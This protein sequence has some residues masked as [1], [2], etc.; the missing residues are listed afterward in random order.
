M[1][2]S[3]HTLFLWPATGWWSKKLYLWTKLWL[4]I[5]IYYQSTSANFPLWSSPSHTPECGFTVHTAV[6]CVAPQSNT[7]VPSENRKQKQKNPRDYNQAKE[8]LHIA[9]TRTEM[10]PE[11]TDAW[12][13]CHTSA[14]P[15]MLTRKASAQTQVADQTTKQ[16]WFQW[17]N[18]SGITQACWRQIIILKR[19]HFDY[20]WDDDWASV[21]K[22]HRSGCICGLILIK[23]STKKCRL[24]SVSGP[25][26]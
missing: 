2:F 19:N 22:E 16:Q 20:L 14:M 21:L 10:E 25:K 13:W 9:Q 1:L 17:W 4:R 11:R 7:S 3:L 26:L 24:D 8:K 18:S 5:Y 12:L 23:S 15:M 6:L